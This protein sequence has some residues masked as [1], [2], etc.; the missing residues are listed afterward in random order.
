M[1][2]MSRDLDTRRAPAD[3]VVQHWTGASGGGGSPEGLLTTDDLGGVS[4]GGVSN[5]PGRL[6]AVACEPRR[7]G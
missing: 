3:P 1:A 7:P 5:G 2:A 4:N 6:A